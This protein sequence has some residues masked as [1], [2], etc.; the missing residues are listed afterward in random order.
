MLIL[1]TVFSMPM[2]IR[3]QEITPADISAARK[4]RKA[5]LNDPIRP[6]WHLTIP[7]G[8]RHALRS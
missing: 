3:S 7:E 1:I 8:S 5:E 6:G 4:I 2:I